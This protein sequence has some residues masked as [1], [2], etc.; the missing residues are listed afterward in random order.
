M[1]RE[2]THGS[3]GGVREAER[4]QRATTTRLFGDRR[5]ISNCRLCSLEEQSEAITGKLPRSITCR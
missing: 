5:V 2:G 1:L 4:M 3:A